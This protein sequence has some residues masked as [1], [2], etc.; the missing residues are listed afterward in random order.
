MKFDGFNEGVLLETK[1][2][3]YAQWIDEKLNFVG[4]FKGRL[5]MLE[6]AKRQFEAANG[7]PLRWI[8][9]EEKLAGALRNMFMKEQLPI[10]VIHVPPT[11]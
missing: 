10:E 7:T 2:T 9:A 4:I 5:Q 8:V 11:P 1:S 6:Q 3:G